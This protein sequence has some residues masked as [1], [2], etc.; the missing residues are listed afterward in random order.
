MSR[1][2]FLHSFIF[3]SATITSSS[4]VAGL[5]D[6]N[7]VDDFVAKKWR[8]TGDTG[9]WIKFDLGSEKDITMIALFGYNLTSGATVTLQANSEDNWTSAPYSK[10]ITWNERALVKFIAEK[11]QWWRI[12]FEDAANPDTYI[13]IGR[14]CCG[15]YYMPPVNIDQEVQ[16]KIVDPSFIQESEGRQGYAIE[17]E[18]YRVYDIRFTGIDRT[19]QGALETMFR[20]VKNINVLV[21]ALDPDNYP[22]E[23]TLYCKLITPLSESLG[24]LGNGDVAL[25]FEEK[26]S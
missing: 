5:P 11:Y 12:Y 22:E 9:E 10:A 8:T 1:V 26:V 25:S 24:A 18:E 19:Q 15:A 4:E 7:V 6:D 21:F 13:E 23:D 3:D 14:I 20:A 2:R 17:K 16:K